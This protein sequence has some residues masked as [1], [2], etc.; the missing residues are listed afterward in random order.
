MAVCPP[1]SNSELAA[2]ARISGAVMGRCVKRVLL[3]SPRRSRRLSKYWRRSSA[4]MSRRSL[5]SAKKVASCAPLCRMPPPS[6]IAGRLSKSSCGS[7]V[8]E[9]PCVE[10]EF[11]LIPPEFLRSSYGI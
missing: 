11:E 8:I 6:P 9:F 4:E 3:S 1:I 7:L 5:Q 10:N 2:S